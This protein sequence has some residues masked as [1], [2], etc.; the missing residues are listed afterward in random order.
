MMRSLKNV[1][2]SFTGQTA[3]AAEKGHLQVLAAAEDAI[4]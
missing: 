1:A 2:Q 3:R 4:L